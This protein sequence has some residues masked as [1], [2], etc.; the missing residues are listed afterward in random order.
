M[1]AM[2]MYYGPEVIYKNNLI[3]NIMNFNEN[4]RNFREKTM[5]KKMG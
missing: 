3:F 5:K 1:N 4:Y 2:T